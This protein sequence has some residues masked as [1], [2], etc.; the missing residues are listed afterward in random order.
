MYILDGIKH[1]VSISYE[2][3]RESVTSKNWPSTK[4]NISAVKQ[5]KTLYLRAG[6]QVHFKKKHFAT[7]V[8]SRMG[9]FRKKRSHKYRVIVDLSWPPGYIQ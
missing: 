3:K 9:A 2:E 1:G 7:F 6:K 5:S 4:N 8:G